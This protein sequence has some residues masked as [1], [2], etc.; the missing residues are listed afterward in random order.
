MSELVS[1]TE[2]R[3][4]LQTSVLGAFAGAAL[5][6]AITGL[7]GVVTYSVRQRRQEIGIRLAL[8]AQS[9][10]ILKSVLLRGIQLTAAGLVLGLLA[11]T[12]LTRFLTSMLYGITPADPATP[13]AVGLL[14]LATAP[15]R[16][17][18]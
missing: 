8:G 17:A 4:R 3:R 7:Y 11:A 18:L 1:A 6:L 14:L 12:A 15:G 10:D 2:G 16:S 9:T 13:A 5:F